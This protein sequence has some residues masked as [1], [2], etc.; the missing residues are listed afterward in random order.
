MARPARSEAL[1]LPAAASIAAGAIHLAS[2][3]AERDRT[4]LA[5]VLAALGIAQTA[6]GAVALARGDG[7]ARTGPAGLRAVGSALAVV[8]FVGWAIAVTTGLPAPP[9]LREPANVGVPDLCAALL[10]LVTAA[11]L[12]RGALVPASDRVDGAGPADRAADAPDPAMADLSASSG[13]SHRSRQAGSGAL[14]GLVALLGLGGVVAVPAASDARRSERAALAAEAAELASTSGEGTSG[15]TPGSVPPFD[16]DRPLDL[17]G[18]PTVTAEQEAAATALVA[19]VLAQREQYPTPEAAYGAGYRSIGDAFTGEEHFIDWSLV[20]DGRA[21]DPAAPEALVYD[22]ADDGTRTL[23]S[24]M[25][26]APPGTR[27]DD[28]PTPGGALTR[29]H[30][31]GDLCLD[32]TTDPASV[33]G[34]TDATGT[35]PDGLEELRRFPTLHV[36]LVRHPCGPFSELEGVGTE[37]G[38][39]AAGCEHQHGT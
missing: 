15:R 1:A 35:C 3:V 33:A 9:A 24:V 34:T 30:L 2:A 7:P 25:F 10:A 28:V 4:T 16:P 38:A 31:H 26:M 5:V 36:W 32:P 12:V 13:A 11:A 6:W 8:A 20:D 22:V 39:A 19:E 18:V 14:V 17:S 21:L 23:V 29:W 37:P 27:L